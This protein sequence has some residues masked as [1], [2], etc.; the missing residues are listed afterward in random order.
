MGYYVRYCVGLERGLTHRPSGR[1]HTPLGA[2]LC[3]PRAQ[4]GLGYWEL[5]G[6]IGRYGRYAY[7]VA[8]VA[9]VSGRQTWRKMSVKDTTPTRVELLQ[10][11]DSTSP[12]TLVPLTTHKWWKPV[13][14]STFTTCPCLA[15]VCVCVCVYVCACVCLCVWVGECRYRYL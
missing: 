14:S 11:S 15:C 12:S 1:P 2:L 5:R 8:P 6:Y 3:G 9:A 4:G 13:A 10:G 7:G